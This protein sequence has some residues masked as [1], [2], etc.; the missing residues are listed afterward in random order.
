MAILLSMFDVNITFDYNMAT[1][2]KNANMFVMKEQEDV[3]KWVR[4]MLL[5]GEVL[6]WS[7]RET[8]KAMILGLRGKAISWASYRQERP[9]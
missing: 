2:D 3:S 1:E 9:T 8:C 6:G 7:E 4:D 5:I